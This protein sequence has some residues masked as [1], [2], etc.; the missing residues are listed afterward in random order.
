M[1]LIRRKTTIIRGNKEIKRDLEIE[2][3]PCF[4]AAIGCERNKRKH[5]QSIRTDITLVL[6]CFVIRITRIKKI[7]NGE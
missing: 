1:E 3:H 4:G 6:L 5:D 7:R 2:V